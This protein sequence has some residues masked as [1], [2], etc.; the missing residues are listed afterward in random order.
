MT[1]K[2]TAQQAAPALRDGQFSRSRRRDRALSRSARLGLSHSSRGRCSAL[3]PVNQMNALDAAY[4]ERP[5]S[6][7][8]RAASTSS[9]LPVNYR[10]FATR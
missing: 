4:A 6:P 9:T 2:A 7:P 5:S 1:E 8:S 3:S 10:S